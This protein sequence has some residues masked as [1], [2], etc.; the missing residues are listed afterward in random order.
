[1]GANSITYSQMPVSTAMCVS[2]M[3]SIPCHVLLSKSS[4]EHMHT[5]PGQQTAVIPFPSKH[6]LI[7]K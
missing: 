6:L 3:Q 4:H 7:L 5:M 1:M 2:K